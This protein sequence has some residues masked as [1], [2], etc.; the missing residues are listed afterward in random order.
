M[1]GR[2]II[3]ES[4]IKR[5]NKELEILKIDK[6]CVLSDKVKLIINAEIISLE[7][8]IDKEEFELWKI[9]REECK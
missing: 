2:K 1:D 9:E 8:R 7:D 6:E 3:V 4:N 5:V